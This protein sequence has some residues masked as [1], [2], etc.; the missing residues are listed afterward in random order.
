MFGFKTMQVLHAVLAVLQWWR[1]TCAVDAARIVGHHLAAAD[2]QHLQELRAGGLAGQQD[3]KRTR[4]RL[5]CGKAVS[6][7]LLQQR[8]S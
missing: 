2:A 3:R 6:G 5:G 4:S 1:H 7:A 8:G